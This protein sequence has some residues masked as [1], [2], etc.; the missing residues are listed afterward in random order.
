M[1]ASSVITRLASSNN[2]TVID[3]KWR[4]KRRV[5]L[6]ETESFQSHA[7]NDTIQLLHSN[8][9]SESFFWFPFLRQKVPR[10]QFTVN[11]IAEFEAVISLQ[12]SLPI[13]VISDEAATLFAY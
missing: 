12:L 2:A 5:K 6:R 9:R 13:L 11:W 8:R 10:L 1:A 7:A 3:P 4:E